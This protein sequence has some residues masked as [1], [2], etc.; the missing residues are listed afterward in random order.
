MRFRGGAPEWPALDTLSQRWT[1]RVG[2]GALY[3][4]FYLAF[5]PSMIWKNLASR[6]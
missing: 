6:K 4:A 3:A 5:A 1:I 2:L